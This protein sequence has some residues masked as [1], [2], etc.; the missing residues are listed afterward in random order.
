MAS[1]LDP[2]LYQN[3]FSIQ[4]FTPTEGGLFFPLKILNDIMLLSIHSY[5]T[6]DVFA[7]VLHLNK[8]LPIQYTISNKA[9][10]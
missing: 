2:K 4:I 6:K 8:Y 5:A 1:L 10:I 7:K 3:E 9:S